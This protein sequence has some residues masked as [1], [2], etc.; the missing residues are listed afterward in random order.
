[1]KRE[2]IKPYLAVESFQLDAALAGSCTD[3]GGE[4]INHYQHSCVDEVYG[5][6]SSQCDTNVTDE[7]NVDDKLCYHGPID[8]LAG[9]FLSS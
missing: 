7:N 3:G 2:Y 8:D 6:F 4:S 5:F 1:M 9:L